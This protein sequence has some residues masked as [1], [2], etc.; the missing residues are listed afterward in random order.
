MLV[1]PA[2]INQSV[3]SA[4]STGQ[5]WLETIGTDDGIPFDHFWQDYDWQNMLS[6]YAR[7]T[8][9]PIPDPHQHQ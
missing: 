3:V 7:P 2:G 5:H 6:H 4:V 1:P 9:H 8:P